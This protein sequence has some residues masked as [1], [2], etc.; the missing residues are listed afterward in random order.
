MVV[1]SL[2]ILAWKNLLKSETFTGLAG[3][4]VSEEAVILGKNS[5]S[6]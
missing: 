6:T 1:K 4:W 5:N 3:E 2:G